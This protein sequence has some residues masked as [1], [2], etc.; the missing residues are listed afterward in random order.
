[1]GTFK[2]TSIL[3]KCKI[4]IIII[5]IIIINSLFAPTQMAGILAQ[6]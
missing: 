1:M 2:A 6:Y 5:I 3:I 4:I